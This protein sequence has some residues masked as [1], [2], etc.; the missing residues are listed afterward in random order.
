ML[1]VIIQKQR[2]LKQMVEKTME[3]PDPGKSLYK[4]VI[5]IRSA[6]AV[7][8]HQRGHCDLRNTAVQ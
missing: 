5:S 7:P 2:E 6:R 1:L 4:K 8:Y 3:R